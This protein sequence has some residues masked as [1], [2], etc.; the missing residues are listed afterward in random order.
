MNFQC[1]PYCDAQTEREING[2][3]LPNICGD[4]RYEDYTRIDDI[5]TKYPKLTSAN[6]PQLIEDAKKA[7]P[8]ICLDCD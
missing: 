7:A 6:L 4:G 3:C 1:V 2:F 5:A 8:Y